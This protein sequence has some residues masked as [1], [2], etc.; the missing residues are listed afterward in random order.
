MDRRLLALA[1]F[2]GAYGISRVK[3]YREAAEGR[4]VFRK[5]GRKVVVSVED[6][7]A[8]ANALPITRP[9]MTRNAV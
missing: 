3:A 8:W 6:A 2:C 5:I 4:L 7:E 9:N 1:D